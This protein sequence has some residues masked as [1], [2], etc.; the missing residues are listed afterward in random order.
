MCTVQ[1]SLFSWLVNHPQK[2]AKIGPLENLPL[3]GLFRTLVIIMLTA[4]VLQLH[5]HMT[6]RSIVRVEFL[7]ISLENLHFAEQVLLETRLNLYQVILNLSLKDNNN[8]NKKKLSKCEIQMYE[9]Y[10]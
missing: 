4:I 10:V 3:Y 1:S 2:T 9:Y 8:N 6:Y 5:G 7:S